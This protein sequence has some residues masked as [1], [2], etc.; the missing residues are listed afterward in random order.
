MANSA[1]TAPSYMANSASTAPSYMATPASTASPNLGYEIAT[2]R[3]G[4]FEG[5]K[6]L[7]LGRLLRHRRKQK[8][9]PERDYRDC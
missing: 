3:C 7:C 2:I 8:S 6:H 4:G 9:G 5:T 1:A